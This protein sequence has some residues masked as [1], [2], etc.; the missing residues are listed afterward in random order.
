ML[1]WFI[2]A[3]VMLKLVATTCDGLLGLGFWKGWML[4]VALVPLSPFTGDLEIMTA[5]LSFQ[6]PQ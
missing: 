6:S 5:L 4:L 2:A 3:G 1:K